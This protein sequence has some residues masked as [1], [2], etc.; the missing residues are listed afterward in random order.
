[1]ADA[2]PPINLDLNGAGDP[3]VIVGEAEVSDR[4]VLLDLAPSL[5][6]EQ[7]VRA[8]AQILNHLARGYQYSVILD[9]EA[10]KAS[11]LAKLAAEDHEQEPEAGEV[12]LSNY[13][14]PDFDAIKPP[15]MDGDTLV[16]YA[17]DSYLGIPYRVEAP[18]SKS[19]LS[20]PVY[21]PMDMDAE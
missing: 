3:V 6:D 5:L 15:E 4:K 12:R 1:M 13:G 9:P 10:F 16:F 11:Y 21:T 18:A 14:K 2:L 7:F 17:E 20:E 8:Y 19:A